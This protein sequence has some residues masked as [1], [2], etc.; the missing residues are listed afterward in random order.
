MITTFRQCKICDAPSNLIGK[1]ILLNHHQVEFFCCTQCGFVQTEEPYWLA[2]AYSQAMTKTDIGQVTRNIACANLTQAL[3][4]FML[5]PDT[6][7]VDYG[8][9]YGLFVR[10]MRDYGYDFYRY[11]KY[12]QNLFAQGFDVEDL[13][14]NNGYELAT[15]FEVFE[16]FVNPKEEIAHLID[17]ADHLLFSTVL[18]AEPPP[19][20]DGWWY[21]GREHGQHVAFY[22]RRT[23]DYL[24]QKHKRYY[25][26]LGRNFHLFAS[27]PLPARQLRFL[28]RERVAALSALFGK[29]KSLVQHDYNRV[30]QS[31]SVATK[32]STP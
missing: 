2:E 5:N 18:I 22:T 20:L 29:K 11:D 23:L 7:S 31:I 16:H 12:A 19:A 28:G 14:Q 24:A 27:K 13:G 9:G 17:M 21:Y 8:G 3:L 4:R 1:T 10:M 26:E 6:R 30:M 15:A 25:Y 32:D